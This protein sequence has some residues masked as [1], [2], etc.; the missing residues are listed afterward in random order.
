MHIKLFNVYSSSL[1]SCT[2]PHKFLI[3]EL[4]YSYTKLPALK[5]VA[6]ELIYP[7]CI[8]KKYIIFYCNVMEAVIYVIRT[9]LY[10]RLRKQDWLTR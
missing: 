8:H 4:I 9:E 2:L 6:I 1:R 10:M 5:T 7:A 3:E